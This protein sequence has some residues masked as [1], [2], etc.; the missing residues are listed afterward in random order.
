MSK[1]LPKD[2][3]MSDHKDIVGQVMHRWK[4][5][6]PKPLHSGRGKGGKEG[7]IVTNPKQAIAIALS[8]AEEEQGSKRSKR[9]LKPGYSENNLNISGFSP[10]SLEKVYELLRFAEEAEAK[11]GINCKPAPKPRSPAQQQATQQAQ[12]QAQQQ[13]QTFDQQ[14]QQQVQEMGRQGGQAER[15]PPLPTCPS[16]E[17]PKT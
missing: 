9:S 4:H 16:E 13:G 8:I 6:D 10:E 17:R 12:Q 7:K 5:H 15:K 1:K 14:P 3:K 2:H 11:P